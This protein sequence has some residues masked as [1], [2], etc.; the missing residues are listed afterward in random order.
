MCKSGKTRK[1]Y[2]ISFKKM[3]LSLLVIS[4]V[5]SPLPPRWRLE[6]IRNITFCLCVMGAKKIP[7]NIN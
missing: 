1:M 4:R 5:E 2:Q 3:Y 6:L 7:I